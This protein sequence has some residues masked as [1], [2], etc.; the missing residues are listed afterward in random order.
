MSEFLIG[1]IVILIY[2]AVMATWFFA[3]F[4]LFM[5]RDIGWRKVLWLFAIVFAPIVGVLAYYVVRPRKA[6][7]EIWMSAP[8]SIYGQQDDSIA[9]QVQ[10]LSQLRSQGAISEDEYIRLKQRV[11]A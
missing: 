3:L 9:F 1:L 5:R 7:E 8:G 2:L 6:P 10:T 11:M 4:D